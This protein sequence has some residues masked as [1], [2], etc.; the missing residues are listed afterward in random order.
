MIA[1]HYLQTTTTD[2]RTNPKIVQTIVQYYTKAQAFESLA[3]FYETVAES[4]IE[5]SRDYKKALEEYR[6]AVKSWNDLLACGARQYEDRCRTVEE[7]INFIGKFLK[8]KEYVG[9][10]LSYNQ[11]IHTMTNQ[12]YFYLCM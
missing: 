9:S 8:I 7:K 3:G 4:E 11:S 6:K 12:N 10:Q 1:A 2:W 5:H